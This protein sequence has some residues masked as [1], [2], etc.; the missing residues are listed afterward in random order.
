MEQTFDGMGWEDGEKWNDTSDQQGIIG[1]LLCRA[2]LW[3]MTSFQQGCTGMIKELLSYG[4]ILVRLFSALPISSVT[5][6]MSRT[7]SNEI[8]SYISGLP[9]GL[10]TTSDD[11]GTVAHFHLSVEPDKTKHLVFPIYVD[12]TRSGSDAEETKKIEDALKALSFR[13]IE[14]K[15]QIIEAYRSAMPPLSGKATFGDLIESYGQGQSALESWVRS[16]AERELSPFQGLISLKVGA[17]GSPPQR[18]L[19]SFADDSAVRSS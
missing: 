16:M 13:S 17:K 7:T 19:Q 8:S 4:P 10:R 14:G 1:G 2:F 11:H 18:T 6:K 15:E 5:P 12:V 9:V 3:H